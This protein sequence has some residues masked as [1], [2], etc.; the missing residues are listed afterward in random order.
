MR[1]VRIS[2]ENAAEVAQHIRGQASPPPEVIG[3]VEE[4][5]RAVRREGDEALFRLAEQLDGVSLSSKELV[6]SREEA[7]EAYEAAPSKLVLAMKR[8]R[9]RLLTL[10]KRLYKRLAL[11][12]TMGGSRIEIR[13]IPLESVG[14]YSPGGSASYPSTVL[15][16][17]VPGTVAGVRR[18]VLATPPRKSEQDRLAVLAASYLAGF[19]EVLWSG[20]AQAIAALAYG[21]QTVKSVKKIVG[22][23]NRYVLEAKRL[24]SRDVAVDFVA[25]P[26]ELLVVVDSSTPFR[27]AALEM[28]AQAEHS[29]D[30]LVGALALDPGSEA[31][32]LRSLS[33]LLKELPHDTPASTSLRTRGFVCTADDWE[34]ARRF[35]DAFAP[36]HLLIYAETGRKRLRDIKSVGVVSYGRH[37]SSVF[38]DYYAGP[39]HVLPTDGWASIRGGLTV[40]DYVKLLPTVRPS[41]TALRRAYRDM[42]ELISAERLPLHLKALEEA[43]RL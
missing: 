43:A 31:A 5:V 2:R 1:V 4:I 27:Q 21:T 7:R 13:P 25:G 17:G 35:I 33:D 34:A 40:L 19:S 16:M 36:E 12:I 32:I 38:L 29:P 28:A 30:T 10:E 15:M 24:V 42:R 11:N 3:A 22:P 37:P 8:L 6:S 9:Q 39:N 18:L 41:K 14:C 23:G 20:G 26:T